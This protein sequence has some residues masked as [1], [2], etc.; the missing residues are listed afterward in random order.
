MAWQV[1]SGDLFNSMECHFFF[2][3]PAA[4]C[5][6]PSAPV[7]DGHMGDALHALEDSCPPLQVHVIIIMIGL[8][9]QS[10]F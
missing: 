2:L 6:F 7:T 4:F 9:L 10:S 5:R 1:R 8:L 3:S